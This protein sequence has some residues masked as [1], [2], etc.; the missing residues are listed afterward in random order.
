MLK[1]ILMSNKNSD[2]GVTVLYYIKYNND[3]DLKEEK[4]YF[5]G[6]FLSDQ[7]KMPP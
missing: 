1:K 2:I 4:R 6:E 7:L 5:I 3:D